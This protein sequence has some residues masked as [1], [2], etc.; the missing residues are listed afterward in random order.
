[1]ALVEVVCRTGVIGL[2]YFRLHRADG[3]PV[4]AGAIMEASGRSI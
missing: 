3:S 4:V 1:M 2:R